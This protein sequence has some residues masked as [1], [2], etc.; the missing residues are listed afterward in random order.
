MSFKV[1]ISG[2]GHESNTFS[3]FSTQKKDFRIIK[4]TPEFVQKTID[5][6]NIQNIEIKQAGLMNIMTGGKISE[7]DFEELLNE[8]LTQIKKELPFNGLLLRMHGGM[9]VENLGHGTT[10][11]LKRIRKLV[12]EETLISCYLDLHG[13][14]PKEFEKYVNIVSALRTAPHVDRIETFQRSAKLLFDSLNNKSTPKTVVI[15]IPM[16]FP[17]EK[18]ITDV[19][20][21]KSLYAK[22]KLI[23]KKPNI[24][25][26]SLMVGFAWADVKQAGSSVIVS[27]EDYDTARS[28]AL[29]LARTFW[30]QRKNFDFDCET[31]E[32]KKA[33]KLANDDPKTVFISDSGD[34]VTAGAA[35]DICEVLDELIKQKIKNTVFAQ[36][37]DEEAVMLCKKNGLGSEIEFYLGG[38]LDTLFGKPYKVKGKVKKISKVGNIETIIFQIDGIDLL[39]TKER[40]PLRT[41]QEFEELGIDLLSKNIVVVKLGYL[42]PPLEEIAPRAIMAFSTG[43]ACQKIEKFS[44]KNIRRP[45]FPLDYDMVWDA[46]K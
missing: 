7:N 44:Y 35:G 10:E 17:G 45:I 36:I 22:L 8:M 31:M 23:D 29:E 34:N 13:N 26:S 15:P 14:I 41:V 9:E 24:L 46:N 2:F 11:V 3:P 43:P 20:P 12:G 6:A 28:E 30:N 37:Y 27:A 19:E 40:F 21:G 32:V 25:A 39:I 5:L 42:Y 1:L 38:K 16:I 4:E 33:I 18:V